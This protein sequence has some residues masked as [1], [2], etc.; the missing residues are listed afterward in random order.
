[1]K[2]VIILVSIDIGIHLFN[3]WD[4][5]RQSKRLKAQLEEKLFGF[6]EKLIRAAEGQR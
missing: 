6:L 2:I 3:M 5:W 1:M 4:R